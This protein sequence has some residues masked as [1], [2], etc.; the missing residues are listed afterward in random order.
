MK[1][2]RPHLAIAAPLAAVLAVG[3]FGVHASCA[4]AD[5]PAL[6]TAASAAPTDGDSGWGR[7]AT[8]TAAVT[9]DDDN[10]SGWG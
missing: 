7:S 2:V 6:T 8:A 3:L 4:P 9:A 1:P 10:D 5:S